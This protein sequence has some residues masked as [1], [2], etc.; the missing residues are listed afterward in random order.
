MP[1]CEIMTMSEKLYLGI[2]IGGT[3][4]AAVLANGSA[5]LHGRKEFATGLGAEGREQ[6]IEALLGAAAEL[7]GTRHIESVGISCG[8]PL[9]AKRGLILCPPNLSGWEEVPIVEIFRKRLQLPAVLENDANAGALA[10]WKFGAGRGVENLIFLTFGTGMGAGL[11]LGGKLYRGAG[12]MAGEVGHIR[13]AEDGPI[14]FHK[15]GSFEGFCSGPGLAQLMASK[16]QALSLEGGLPDTENLPK[17]PEQ[18]T[19]K[20]VVRLA[21]EGNE[22][23]L[24]VVRESGEHLG[25][26]IAILIDTLNPELVV[27]GSMGVRLGDL[28]LDPARRVVHE[29]AIASSAETCSI[30]PPDLG[31]AVGDH[32]ALCVALEYE[33]QGDTNGICDSHG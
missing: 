33:Y 2:D 19:G 18:L 32:A 25:R 9:D 11:I 6:T 14:G 10:E 21:L 17:D 30:V 26:G 24:Q 4:C 12:G 3:K 15:K 22:L 7:A 23:A 20:D 8:G 1:G 16:V 29:E 28:L 27:V 31:E 5:T 13:L